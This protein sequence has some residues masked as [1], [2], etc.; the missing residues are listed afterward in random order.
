MRL[1]NR[2]NEGRATLAARSQASKATQEVL[3]AYFAI[4]AAKVS[5]AIVIVVT[6]KIYITSGSE[7]WLAF[8]IG[9]VS[10]IDTG[11]NYV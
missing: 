4:F 2:I 3:H 10:T 9:I 5:E 11:F 7:D 8:I 1:N 6:D